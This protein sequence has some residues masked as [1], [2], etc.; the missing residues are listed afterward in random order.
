MKLE[1]AFLMLL[2]ADDHKPI[3]SIEHMEWMLY[4]LAKTDPEL[5]L[6]MEMSRIALEHKS[7]CER[8]E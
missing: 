7:H 5:M 3:K 2:A 8:F 4:L 1:E 6:E